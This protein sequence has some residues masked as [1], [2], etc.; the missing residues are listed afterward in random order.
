MMRMC[1]HSIAKMQCTLIIILRN[2][3]FSSRHASGVAF[4]I[5]LPLNKT[6]A[7]SF[8]QSSECFQLKLTKS[9]ALNLW[10]GLNSIYW[11]IYKHKMSIHKLNK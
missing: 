10:V 11:K 1:W 3:T 9:D 4:K 2:G 6:E 7:A 5:L 8:L